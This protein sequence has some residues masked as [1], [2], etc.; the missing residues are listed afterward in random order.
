MGRWKNKPRQ[1][2]DLDVLRLEYVYLNKRWIVKSL[3]CLFTDSRSL[4]K[5]DAIELWIIKK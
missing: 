1:L 2:L 3:N 4:Y 5:Y